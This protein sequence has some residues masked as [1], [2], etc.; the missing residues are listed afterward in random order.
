M[1]WH[2]ATI[3]NAASIFQ[4]VTDR[5]TSSLKTGPIS[6]EKLRK[7]PHYADGPLPPNFYTGKPSRSINVLLLWLSECSSP[8]WLTFKQALNATIRKLST[9]RRLSSASSFPNGPRKARK[10]PAR[11]SAFLLLS[12]VTR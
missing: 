7:T 11:A 12:A 10:A 8:F 5:T 1:S 9:K 4:T 2:T 6:W 3:R